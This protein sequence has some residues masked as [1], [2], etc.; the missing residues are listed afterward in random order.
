MGL[1][2]L[3]THAWSDPKRHENPSTPLR[4]NCTPKVRLRTDSSG[5]ELREIERKLFPVRVYSRDSRAQLP[6]RLCRSGESAVGAGLLLHHFG[7]LVEQLAGE[8]IDRH[9]HSV[10]LRGCFRGTPPRRVAAT[11]CSEVASPRNT[12]R[13]IAVTI[14]SSCNAVNAIRSPITAAATAALSRSG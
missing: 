12:F 3:F 2:P 6:L 5:G 4:G 8:A 11:T 1:A 7:L 14:S 9:G 10:Q 13:C